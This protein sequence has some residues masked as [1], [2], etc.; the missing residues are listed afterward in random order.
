MIIVALSADKT[1]GLAVDVRL[2]I[3]L[4]TR[5][6]I[7]YT[8]NHA[9]PQPGHMQCHINSQ[10]FEAGQ[11]SDIHPTIRRNT[12]TM[13]RI[14]HPRSLFCRNTAP[15]QPYIEN[16]DTQEPD[17]QPILSPSA[18]SWENITDFQNLL[19][20]WEA[21]RPDEPTTPE[22][23][24][25]APANNATELAAPPV[26]PPS[27]FNWTLSDDH[28][29]MTFSTAKC[30]HAIPAKV[31]YSCGDVS[32]EFLLEQV[33]QREKLE[34]D[35]RRMKSEHRSYVRET[36]DA[37]QELRREADEARGRLRDI[38]SRFRWLAEGMGFYEAI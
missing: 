24:P 27:M 14:P 30:R 36:D 34:R 12:Y 8:M 11:L 18:N 20:S 31:Y 13:P 23:S 1:R 32:C 33:H 21:F 2:A 37:M 22:P 25:K 17:Q 7:C 38:L 35:L 16:A 10:P 4:R 28:E 6:S 3:R 26:S 15:P 9:H 19:T 5:L 29:T